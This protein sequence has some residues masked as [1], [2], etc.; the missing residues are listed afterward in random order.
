MIILFISHF[1]SSA[2]ENEKY[3]WNGTYEIISH[4]VPDHYDG[5]IQLNY[6]NYIVNSTVEVSLPLR[7]ETLVQL[8]C[9][10][11]DRVPRQR[12]TLT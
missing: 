9:L 7:K 12:M 2:N 8:H 5:G 10:N 11:S 1:S 4:W 6:F 3:F